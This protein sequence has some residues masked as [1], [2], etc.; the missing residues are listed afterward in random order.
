MGNKLY[1]SRNERM[2]FGICGGLGQYMGVDPTVVRIIF[3]LLA[4]CGGA[5]ALAYIIMAFLVPLEESKKT[6]TQ[7]I[8][9]ENVADI[10]ETAT[11]LSQGIQDTFKGNGEETEEIAQVQERRR[12]ALGIIIIVIGVICLLGALNIFRWSHWFAVIAAVALIAF[13]ILLIVGLSKKQ[14]SQ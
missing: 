13:G 4:F 11:K 9:E 3:V 12:N 1:R 5:G 14:K 2:L 10:K 7:D 8:V 6:N